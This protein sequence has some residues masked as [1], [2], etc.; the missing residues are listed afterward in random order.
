MDGRLGSWVLFAKGAERRLVGVPIGSAHPF[1]QGR[2]VLGPLPRRASS[3]VCVDAEA[4]DRA[5]GVIAHNSLALPADGLRARSHGGRT[6]SG[7]AT[8]DFVRGAGSCPSG[9]S[10]RYRAPDLADRGCSRAPALVHLGSCVHAPRRRRSAAVGRGCVVGRAVRAA[11]GGRARARMRNRDQ[12]VGSQ[13][14]AAR[15]DVANP[16]RPAT[17]RLCCGCDRDCLVAAFRHRGTRDPGSPQRYQRSG[18]ADVPV[19]LAR[20]ADATGS[21]S[22]DSARTRDSGL[23]GHG[24]A[25]P[26]VGRASRRDGCPSRT[27]LADVELLRRCPRHMRAAVRPV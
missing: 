23:C 3:R 10:C 14:S 5:A 4:A 6:R 12:A 21:R 11:V 25:R 8:D 9:R 13:L 20:R 19:V 17:G 26:L 15:R 2:L 27:G 24:S 18:R 1:R 22:R 16:R 7:R